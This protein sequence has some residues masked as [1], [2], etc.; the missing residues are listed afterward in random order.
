MKSFFHS[1]FPLIA[2]R[3]PRAAHGRKIAKAFFFEFIKTK[4]EI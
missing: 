2:G 1:P 4:P 3:W